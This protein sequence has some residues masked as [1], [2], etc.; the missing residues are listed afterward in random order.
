MVVVAGEEKE[1]HRSN[2]KYHTVNQVENTLY[3]PAA[4]VIPSLVVAD[5]DV[6]VFVAD[7]R[8]HHE[9]QTDHTCEHVCNPHNDVDGVVKMGV[10]TAD[11]RVLQVPDCAAQL[12]VHNLL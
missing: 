5:V 9:A 1:Q 2:H 7:D 4:V 11:L 8:N 3:H 10:F 6:T 12:A